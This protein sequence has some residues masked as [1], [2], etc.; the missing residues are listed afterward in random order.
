MADNLRQLLVCFLKHSLVL[1]SW[2]MTKMR[3]TDKTVSFSVSGF[4]YKGP[5]LIL[6]KKNEYIITLLGYEQVHCKS[7]Y[8]VLNVLDSLIETSDDYISNIRDWLLQ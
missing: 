6:C 2:G 1:E 7:P 4:R 8:I 5:I 3:F